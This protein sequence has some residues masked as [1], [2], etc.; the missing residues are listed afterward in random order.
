MLASRVLGND[1]GRDRLSLVVVA[2]ADFGAL[3]LV[4]SDD[5]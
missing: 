1:G 2:V 3:L 5:P 4:A